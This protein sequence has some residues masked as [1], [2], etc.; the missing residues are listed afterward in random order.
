[1]TTI[2]VHLAQLLNEQTGAEELHMHDSSSAL[3]T[4][5]TPLPNK[6]SPRKGKHKKQKLKGKSLVPAQKNEGC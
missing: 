5:Q 4:A 3:I 1:M 2:I 6:G